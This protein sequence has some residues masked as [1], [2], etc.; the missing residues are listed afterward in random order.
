MT[1]PANRNDINNTIKN[2]TQSESESAR[3]SVN[4]SSLES[5]LRTWFE[6]GLTRQSTAV[7][8]PAVTPPNVAQLAARLY[9]RGIAGL[10]DSTGKIWPIARADESSKDCLVPPMSFLTRSEITSSLLV[11]PANRYFI[12]DTNF[13]RAWPEWQEFASLYPESCYLFTPSE[14]AK[15]L[16]TVLHMCDSLPAKCSEI[17]AA[18]GGI[19]SD[20]A[21][22]VSG[23]TGLPC[24]TLPTTLLSAVDAS[25]GGKTGANFLPYGKNQVGLFVPIRSLAIVP[26]Y[27]QSLDPLTFA[28]GLAEALKHTWLAGDFE[29][30]KPLLKRLLLAPPAEALEVDLVALIEHSYQLKASVVLE[31]PFER[32]IR[33]FLNLGHTLGHCV[34]GLGEAGATPSLPHGM[35]VALGMKVLI[36]ANFLPG[37]P[38]GFV[39]FLEELLGA[40]ECKLPL[41]TSKPWPEVW[42]LC[43]VLLTGDK[44]NVTLEPGA[45]FVVPPYGVLKNRQGAD[46]THA[47]PTF[48]VFLPLETVAK[49]FI[50][51]LFTTPKES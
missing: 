42:H 46:L 43:G 26:E 17:F 21:G 7:F 16:T 18:G 23:L 40:G 25:I 36:S 13:I 12:L 51:H 19:T 10:H 44:K 32:G 27:F 1:E 14:S 38:I 30:L 45:C 3:L 34:E 33:K 9:K 20:L 31:D 4:V 2:A 5:C 41:L 37:P 35:C 49:Q 28:C 50:P 39:D 15:N 47:T 29:T 6:Q 11:A 8:D 48:E 22:F 24:D